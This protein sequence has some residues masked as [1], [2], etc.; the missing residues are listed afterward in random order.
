MTIQA[1]ETSYAGCRFRSRLEARWAV[2]FDYMGVR[3]EY[4]PQGF[5]TEHGLYLPDFRL[6]DIRT[7]VE[8]KGPVPTDHEFNLCGEVAK[9][10]QQ[11]NG[12]LY[13]FSGGIPRGILVPTEYGYDVTRGFWKF[14]PGRGWGE[15]SSDEMFMYHRFGT[16]DK[17][18]EV[19]AAFTAARSAR[20]EHGESGSPF[21]LPGRN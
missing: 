17:A 1:I 7:F 9:V 12:N 13:I 8:I 6:P 15:V 11:F 5:E 19:D 20:F 10:C 3:W 16:H 2:F 21:P 14:Y 4:E 18:S